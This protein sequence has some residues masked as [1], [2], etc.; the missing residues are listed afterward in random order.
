MEFFI[1]IAAVVIIAGVAKAL[2]S[3]TPVHP[4]RRVRALKAARPAP[5]GSTSAYLDTSDSFS[6]PTMTS[7][8][9]SAV[10]PQ[11]LDDH[12][13]NTDS[14]TSWDGGADGCAPA[15]SGSWDSGGDSGGDFD[16]GGCD[17]GSSD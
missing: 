9:S 1:L 10:D 13:R 4:R 11:P 14:G 7:Y 6:S 5:A 12:T 16:S 8:D 15:D 2:D 17:S 3:S